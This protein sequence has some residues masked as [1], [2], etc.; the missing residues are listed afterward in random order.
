MVTDEFNIESLV[1]AEPP[2]KALARHRADADDAAQSH[3]SGS[4][5]VR[6]ELTAYIP[7][8]KRHG[9]IV[10]LPETDE[11]RQFKVLRRWYQ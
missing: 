4:T 10:D 3:R 8:A 11:T 6:E 1:G 9:R 5:F 7:R 2:E